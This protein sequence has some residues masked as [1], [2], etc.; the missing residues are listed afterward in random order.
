VR[1]QVDAGGLVAAI[2]EP[3][4]PAGPLSTWGW[5][6]RQSVLTGLSASGL[7]DRL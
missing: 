3:L 7:W 5:V 6:A 1:W 2:H 4:D